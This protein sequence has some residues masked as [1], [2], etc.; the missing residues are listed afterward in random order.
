MP[1]IVTLCCSGFSEIIVPKSA[2]RLAL[3]RH[4][5][6]QHNILQADARVVITVNRRQVETMILFEV[7]TVSYHSRVYTNVSNIVC[8]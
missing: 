3:F 8:N 7:F 2:L 1:A 4:A 5:V 6:S